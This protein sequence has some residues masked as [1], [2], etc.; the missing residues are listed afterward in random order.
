[1]GHERELRQLEFLE[2]HR[3][4]LHA[5]R[6]ETYANFYRCFARYSLA[7][8]ALVE[9]MQGVELQVSESGEPDLA[10]YDEAMAE[11]LGT[12]RALDEALMLVELVASAEVRENAR[13]L[14]RVRHDVPQV[15]AY[16]EVPE[17]RE[18]YEELQH[19][20]YVRELRLREA[21]RAELE[22]D[23]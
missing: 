20:V 9:A 1:M 10:P 14:Q 19:L 23:R 6:R 2:A 3:A 5:D 16:P 17:A 13:E 21:I 4:Q 7:D 11:V 12:Y 22:L 18:A 8:R 15:V